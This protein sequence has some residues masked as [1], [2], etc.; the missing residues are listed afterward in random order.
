MKRQTETV[1]IKST[2]LCERCEKESCEDIILNTP[3]DFQ[4]KEKE[5][6]L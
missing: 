2:D 6:E 1:Y 3:C 5:F 4:P